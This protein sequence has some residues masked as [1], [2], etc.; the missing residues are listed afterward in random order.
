[1]A[2]WPYNTTQW[3]RIRR[4]VLQRQP[5]CAACLELGYAAKAEVVDH[6][7]PVR[8]RPDLA[9]TMTNL[10]GLCKLCHDA[11]KQK[12]EKRG[13]EIGCGRDGVPRSAAHWW[14]E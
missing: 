13:H 8:D 2:D 10:R 5:V 6:I 14:N 1:M 4:M 11:A 9:F 12:E 7:E 3:Q